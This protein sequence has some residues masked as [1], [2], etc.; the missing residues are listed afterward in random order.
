MTTE[1]LFNGVMNTPRIHEGVVASVK[2]L[3][4]C[5][6]KMAEKQAKYNADWHDDPE[7]SDHA[8]YHAPHLEQFPQQVRDETVKDLVAYFLQE[9]K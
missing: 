6:D 4:L 7:A 9:L 1:D 8:E 3:R 5:I 2:H